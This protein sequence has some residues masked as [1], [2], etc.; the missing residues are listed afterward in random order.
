MIRQSCLA[1]KVCHKSSR[2][3]ITI[4]SF[5]LIKELYIVSFKVV[6]LEFNVHFYLYF[7][8][9]DALLERLLGD[10]PKLFVTAF[11]MESVLEKCVP[12]MMFLTLGK[13]KKSHGAKSGE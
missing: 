10:S 7:S 8:C 5:N 3:E 11:L 2:T 13:R 9:I 1:Y 4:I 6:P 12:L